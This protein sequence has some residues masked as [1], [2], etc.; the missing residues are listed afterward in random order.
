MHRENEASALAI[1]YAAIAN[2]DAYAKRNLLVEVFAAETR[3]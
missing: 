3:P 2:R 1:G